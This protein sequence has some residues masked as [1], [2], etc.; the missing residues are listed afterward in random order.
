MHCIFFIPAVVPVTSVANNVAWTLMRWKWYYSESF[1]NIGRFF[2]LH[3]CN[4]LLQLITNVI[5]QR[6]GFRS[7]LVV[8]M[9]GTHIFP[10]VLDKFPQS[11]MAPTHG[12]QTTDDSHTHTKTGCFYLFIFLIP[13][14]IRKLSQ[15]VWF[16]CPTVV[17]FPAVGGTKSGSLK[18]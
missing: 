4:I 7:H 2:R 10:L 9:N 14:L 12:A 11:Q 15:E 17:R 1:L 3:S 8:N 13:L 5:E 18:L 6:D 16:F